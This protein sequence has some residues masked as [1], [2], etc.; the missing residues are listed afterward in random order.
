[1][2]MMI[3][4]MHL[5]THIKFGEYIVGSTSKTVS[6]ITVINNNTL[7]LQT[8]SGTGFAKG[9]IIKGR[10]GGRETSVVSYKENTILANNRLLDYSD[11]DHTTEDFLNYFQTDLA[12]A[13]DL[14]LTMNKRLTIKNIKD[15]YQQKGTEDSLKFLMRLLYWGRCRGALPLQRNNICI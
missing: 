15:L 2:V 8:I 1:M 7:Y 11:I 4:Q 6:K 10:E 12:P 13:F 9:E 14:G 5:P 3:A